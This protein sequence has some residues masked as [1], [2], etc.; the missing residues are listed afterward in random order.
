MMEPH[1][2]AAAQQQS[3]PGDCARA[4]LFGS[5]WRRRC[6][7][8]TLPAPLHRSASGLPTDARADKNCLDEDGVAITVVS[9]ETGVV[10]NSTDKAFGVAPR[11]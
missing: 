10:R 8:A 3:S 11:A 2:P 1:L 4:L 7:V 6:F 9:L 5:E